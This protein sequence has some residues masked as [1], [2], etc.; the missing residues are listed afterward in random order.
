[1]MERRFESRFL[2]SDLIQVDWAAGAASPRSVE[3]VLEDISSLGACVQV[4]E[5]IP[6]G[7]AI[8]MLVPGGETVRFSGH[9]AYC[10][11]RDFGYFVGIRFSNGTRWSSG[12][13][14]PMH[15]TNLRDLVPD[16]A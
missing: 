3:A 1:M 6:P 13:F 12:I 14:Q 2:C 5:S 11:Y 16:D 7:A 15:L 10:I 8:S 9:V 4:E